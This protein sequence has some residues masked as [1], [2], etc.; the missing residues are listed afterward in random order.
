MALY[1]CG[2]ANNTNKPTSLELTIYGGSTSSSGSTT[3]IGGISFT[4]D[5]YTRV[6]YVSGS[7]TLRVLNGQSVIA[8]LNTAGSYQIIFNITDLS[9]DINGTL[10]SQPN[11]IIRFEYDPSDIINQN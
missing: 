3:L 2:M 1:R 6:T 11:A 10:S 8:H 9:V 4:N 7:G 5:L